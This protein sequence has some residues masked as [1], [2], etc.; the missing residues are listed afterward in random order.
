M[1]GRHHQSIIAPWNK[2]LKMLQTIDFTWPQLSLGT[3]PLCYSGSM[4][5]GTFSQLTTGTWQLLILSTLHFLASKECLHFG[6]CASTCFKSLTRLKLEGHRKRS[7]LVLCSW[8]TCET[9]QS[10]EDLTLGWLSQAPWAVGSR[11]ISHGKLFAV[12][13]WPQ[14]FNSLQ[15]FAYSSNPD[16]FQVSGSGEIYS[17]DK[18][19]AGT[20]LSE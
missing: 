15:L 11:F 4:V 10:C 5:P 16:M 6:F 12:A 9:L 8:I 2:L 20:R 3:G 18:K 7:H 14:F 19:W 17:I 1:P 13:Y